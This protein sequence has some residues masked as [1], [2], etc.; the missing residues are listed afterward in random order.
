MGP[1]VELSV[2]SCDH[3][4]VKE[5]KLHR[6]FIVDTTVLGSDEDKVKRGV[7]QGRP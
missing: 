1:L 4:D 7:S 6:S 5:S 3:M 2:E